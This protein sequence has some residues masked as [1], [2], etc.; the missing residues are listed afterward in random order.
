MET[1]APAPRSPAQ[2]AASRANGRR[3]TGRLRADPDDITR[4]ARAIE[5][6]CR[7]L[8]I[9]APA[10]A[11][12]L[13]CPTCA[14]RASPA[15]LVRHMTREHMTREGHPATRTVPPQGAARIVAR[16]LRR[17]ARAAQKA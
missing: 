3:Y 16:H 4:Y 17:I 9:P 2:V 14:I 5:H 1:N 13:G 10:P 6:A 15:D 7:E 8:A 12:L 11:A